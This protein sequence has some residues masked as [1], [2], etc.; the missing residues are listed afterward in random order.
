M[1]PIVLTS[2][3][4]DGKTL[5]AYD[6]ADVRLAQASCCTMRR[7]SRVVPSHSPGRSS[8]DTSVSDPTPTAYSTA[9]V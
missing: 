4:G 8:T 7:A 3:T 2:Q 9:Q 1:K 5:A 6:I